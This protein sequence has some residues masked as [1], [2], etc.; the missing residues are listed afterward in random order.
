MA[1]RAPSS[2]A[3][4]VPCLS[5]AGAQRVAETLAREFARSTR[6]TVVT[7]EPRL[8]RAELAGLDE[9]PWADR[10]PPGCRHVHLPSTGSGLRRFGQ[11]VARFSA[12]ARRERFDA[13]YSFLTWTNVVVSAARAAGGGYLHVASEHAMAES[14]RS[15]GAGLSLLARTL[16]V[17]YRRPDRIV[18]VSD[19]AARSLGEEGLLPHPERVV[20]IPNPV[21][22]AEV[23]RL[24]GAT[25]D[26]G[27]PRTAG[28]RVL[29]CVARLHAQKDHLTLLRALRA[30]PD[31][32]VLRLVGEGPLRPELETAVAGM[33]LTGRVTFTG[34]LANPYPLMRE[35]DVVVLPSREEGFG[36]VAVEAAVLGVPFVGSATGGLAEVCAALGHR[37]FLPGDAEA[38]ATAIEEAAASPVPAGTAELA[39]A[40]FDP[41]EVAA[42]YLALAGGG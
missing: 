18:V 1:G 23:Q 40:L 28:E 9:L 32:F 19:A 13:V 2:V 27:A 4:V 15:D 8:T 12:L 11:V 10:I 5:G 21:D 24:A 41:A 26:P 39:A 22:A 6:V 34:Q 35:A 17:V 42:R 14:L 7:V 20:T 16:P 31:R 36:L 38:L 25:A 29:M 3:V 30:L 37:T 33:G